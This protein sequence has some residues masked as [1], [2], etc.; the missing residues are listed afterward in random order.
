LQ[1]VKKT[2]KN[3]PTADKNDSKKKYLFW[4]FPQKLKNLNLTLF[5]LK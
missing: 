5:L 3:N 4:I 1:Y 2:L